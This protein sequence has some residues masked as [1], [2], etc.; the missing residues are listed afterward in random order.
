MVNESEVFNRDGTFK[1]RQKNK[2]Q[3]TPATDSKDTI[4]SNGRK[5]P[6]KYLKKNTAIEVKVESNEIRINN[7]IVRVLKPNEKLL[8]DISSRITSLQTMLLESNSLL[9]DNKD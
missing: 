8:K 7:T 3:G 6:K 5:K 4:L 9:E 2:K 1:A